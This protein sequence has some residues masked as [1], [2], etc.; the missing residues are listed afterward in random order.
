[1]DQCGI[2]KSVLTAL[3]KRALLGL[4]PFKTWNDEIVRAEAEAEMNALDSIQAAARDD[5][6]AAAWYMERRFPQRWG[7]VNQHELTG[8]GGG[9]LVIDSNENKSPAVARELIAK[10]FGG[11]LQASANPDQDTIDAEIEEDVEAESDD[12]SDQDT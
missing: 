9:A 12:G 8:A 1:L 2:N 10:V 3:R 4:E 5:W 6:K 7:K 11:P